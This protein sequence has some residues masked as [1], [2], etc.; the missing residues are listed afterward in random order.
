M[1]L[2]ALL[3]PGAQNLVTAMLGDAWTSTRDAIARRWGKGDKTSTDQAVAELDDSRSQAIALFAAGEPDERLLEAFVAGYLAA[4]V[5]AR[6]DRV[7]AI[8]ELGAAS[9]PGSARGGNHN[10]GRVGKLVQIDGD[11]DGGI[12]M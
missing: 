1:D 6:P 7:E 9:Q 3:L 2:S 8:I 4:I 10:S 12:R 11:V 5:R